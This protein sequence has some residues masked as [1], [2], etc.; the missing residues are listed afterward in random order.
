[1]FLISPSSTEERVAHKKNEALQE[2]NKLK[3]E[4]YERELRKLQTKLMEMQAWVTATGA[5]IVLVFE[6]RD[7][8]GKGGV[9]HP[10]W[11]ASAPGGVPS[12]GFA[13]FPQS[14]KS[15]SC[16]RSDT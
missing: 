1:L 4:E 14:E 8:A 16:T 5:K 9:I 15:H 13:S 3:A 6:G 7:A 10:L 2:K 12:C 11:S